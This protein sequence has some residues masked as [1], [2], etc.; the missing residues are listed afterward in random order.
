MI[1][2]PKLMTLKYIFFIVVLLLNNNTIAAVKF[3]N[4]KKLIPYIATYKV[5]WKNIPVANSVHTLKDIGNNNYIAE[6]DSTPTTMLI[7]ITQYERSEFNI[8]NFHIWPN[9]YIINST[10]KGKAKNRILAFNWQQYNVADEMT[11]EIAFKKISSLTQDVVSHS[12]QLKLD[13]MHNKAALNY[14]IVKFDKMSN[15]NFKIVGEEKLKTSIGEF[16]AII[17]KNNKPEYNRSTTMWLAHDLS[18]TMIKLE[19]Y[20]KGKLFNKMHIKSYNAITKS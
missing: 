20:R 4:N 19:Q 6:I 18:L 9:K 5:Y 14:P 10:E 16:N 3:K 15:Y 17:V 12:F 1:R 8:I 7:P 11:N 13:L 2:L